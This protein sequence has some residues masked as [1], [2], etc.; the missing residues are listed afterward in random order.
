MIAPGT[1]KLRPTSDQLRETLFNVI[2][3]A[4]EGSVFIDVFA[5]TGAVGI[6]A[7]SRGAREVIFIEKHR[8]TAAALIRRNLTAFKIDA[9]ICEEDWQ[10]AF[11]KLTGRGVKA[12]FIFADP[13]YA[14]FGA[15]QEVLQFVGESELLSPGGLVIAEHAKRN[16]MPEQLGSLRK[17]RKLLQGD[18][19]LEFYGR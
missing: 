17:R 5:G 2:G 9:E 10:S 8:A 19:A 18:S 15:L 6:E 7:I 4:I 12:D 13:P 16:E 11:Q 1:L 14:G 3:P